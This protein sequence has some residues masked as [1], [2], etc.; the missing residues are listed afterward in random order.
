MT[1]AGR[2]AGASGPQRLHRPP[3]RPAREEHEEG[4]GEVVASVP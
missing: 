1:V 4:G 2:F 3:L